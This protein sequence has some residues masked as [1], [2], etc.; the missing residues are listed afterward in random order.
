MFS[1][2]FNEILYLSYFFGVYTSGMD[3]D[4][5]PDF[6]IQ[7]KRTF[8]VLVIQSIQHKKLRKKATKCPISQIILNILGIKDKNI[9]I[10]SVEEANTTTIL[11]KSI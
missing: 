7:K 5:M 3:R 11:L 10:I 1:S 2:I 6:F 9:K 8:A 4:S